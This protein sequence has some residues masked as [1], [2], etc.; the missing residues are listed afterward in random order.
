MAAKRAV[1]LLS[2]GLDSATCLAW[3]VAEGYECATL[4]FDYGQRHAVEMAQR[5]VVRAAIAQRFPRW[6]G[7]LGEDHVLDLTGFG[8]VG[9]TAAKTSANKACT[10]TCTC[11]ST[12][13]S[14]SSLKISTAAKP[15]R[16]VSASD[17]SA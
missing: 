15:R 14:S 17:R 11:S 5:Q 4:A 1:V 12:E 16:S 3:A 8:A 2:G 6:A 9:E 7:K 13:S 10:A